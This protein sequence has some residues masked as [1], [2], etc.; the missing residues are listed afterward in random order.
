MSGDCQGQAGGRNPPPSTNRME[1][2]YS[3]TV[4][5]NL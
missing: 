5:A 3:S 1:V 4:E 2:M